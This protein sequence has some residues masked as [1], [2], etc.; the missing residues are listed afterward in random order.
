MQE[1]QARVKHLQRENDQLWSQVEKKFLNLERTYEMVI[2]L[3]IQKSVIKKKSPLFS[4]TMT[5]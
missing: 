3:N 1:L 5:P 2:V 4:T